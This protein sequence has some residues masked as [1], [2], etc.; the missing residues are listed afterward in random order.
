M[1]RVGQLPEREQV[2]PRI[3]RRDVERERGL[4]LGQQLAP[5]GGRGLAFG[6][7]VSASSASSS[8]VWTWAIGSTSQRA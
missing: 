8:R 7:A 5:D 6:L 1:G 4:D 3:I 2:A